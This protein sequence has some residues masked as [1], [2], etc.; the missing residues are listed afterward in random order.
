MRN[1]TGSPNR[2]QAQKGLAVRPE[3]NVGRP[4]RHRLASIRY[5]P[6]PMACSLWGSPIEVSQYRRGLNALTVRRRR[7]AIAR[8]IAPLLGV[9]RLLPDSESIHAR[10]SIRATGWS[11]SV[12][13]RIAKSKRSMSSA[14]SR[15][16]GW[17]G[18]DGLWKRD[19]SPPA[20]KAHCFGVALPALQD[21]T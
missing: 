3:R 18:S 5:A 14:M 12:F 2:W 13:T 19:I 10:R 11:S 7:P 15:S 9:R 1:R 8:I 6:L 16:R 17:C 20:R 4:C 21:V